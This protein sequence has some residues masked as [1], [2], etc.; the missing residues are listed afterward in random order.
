MHTGPQRTDAR[1]GDKLYSPLL[2]WHHPRMFSVCSDIM[3][4]YIGF[5]GREF[6][7]PAGKYL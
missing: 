3:Q 2:M 6:F 7:R 4:I 5:P 1:D